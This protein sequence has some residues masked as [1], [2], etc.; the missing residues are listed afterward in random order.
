MSHSNH[1]LVYLK[2]FQSLKVFCRFQGNGKFCHV[3]SLFLA[4]SLHGKQT[5]ALLKFRPSKWTNNPFWQ[6]LNN[7]FLPSS[8]SNFHL[9]L[10]IFPKWENGMMPR[11]SVH[12]LPSCYAPVGSPKQPQGSVEGT[13]ILHH[14]AWLPCSS[15]LHCPAWWFSL[16]LCS[17]TVQTPPLALWL[18][19]VLVWTW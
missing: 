15:T 14:T 2:T 19:L 12:C 4:I 13:T 1:V 5:P 11:P 6:W 10:L 9:F 7:I 3:S 16:N 18:K 8:Y 17:E